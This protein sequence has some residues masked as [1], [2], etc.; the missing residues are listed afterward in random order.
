MFIMYEVCL[1]A[2]V[3]VCICT[4]RLWFKGDILELSAVIISLCVNLCADLSCM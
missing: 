3:C 2:F 4:G 1:C